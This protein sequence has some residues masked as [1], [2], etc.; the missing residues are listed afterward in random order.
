MIQLTCSNCGKR[1]RAKPEWVGRT[2]KCPGCGQAIKVETSP[3]AENIP[4]EQPV[5]DAPPAAPVEGAVF[6]PPEQLD[7]QHCYLICDRNNAVASWENN[8]DGWMLQT[9][10]GSMPAR[11]N[12]DKLPQQGDFRLI[13][14]K[15]TATP[16]GKRLT[17]LQ[18]YRLASHWAL[19]ALEQGDDVI[20]E[21]VAGPG[22]L[23]R[24]QKTIVRQA[25]RDRFMRP[26]WQDATAVL[27]YLASTDAHSSSIG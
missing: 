16:D 22:G 27:D 1:L 20:L 10:V 12:H 11:R 13:E 7:R 18:C 4:L 15:L 5:P 9:R 2:A 6:H 24:E 19:M 3:P 25:L 8:G 23:T 14:L 17:G 21:R 26:V